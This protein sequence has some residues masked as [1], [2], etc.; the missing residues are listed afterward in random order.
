M[1]FSTLLIQIARSSS[2]EIYILGSKASVFCLVSTITGEKILNI[3]SLLKNVLYY[4]WAY[5]ISSLTWI[6][7]Q[8]PV[9]HI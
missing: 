5:K 3:Y 6:H 1:Q 9:L 7:M 8:T 4:I 2:Y